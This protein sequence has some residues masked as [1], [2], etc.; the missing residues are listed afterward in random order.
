[1]GV[2]WVAFVGLWLGLGLVLLVVGA[3]VSTYFH[4]LKQDGHKV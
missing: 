1:M 3:G 4:K 2:I